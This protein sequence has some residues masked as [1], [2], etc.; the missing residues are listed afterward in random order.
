MSS[1]RN[2]IYNHLANDNTISNTVADYDDSEAIFLKAPVPGDAPFPRI[3]S[4]FNSGDNRE[5]WSGKGDES[6][7]RD[8]TRNLRIYGDVESRTGDIQDLAMAVSDRFHLNENEPSFDGY[9]T[10]RSTASGPT[11]A[12]TTDDEVTGRLVTI[13]L[14]LEPN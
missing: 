7:A 4:E 3:V 6:E 10:I 9:T 13:T 14:T 2:G 12:P 8:I 1:I 5:A 11:Q